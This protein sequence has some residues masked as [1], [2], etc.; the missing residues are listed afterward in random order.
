MLL[1][2]KNHELCLWVGCGEKNSIQ[3]SDGG[4]RLKDNIKMDRR[5]VDCED[6]TSGRGGEERNSRPLP[7]LEPPTI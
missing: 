3:N 4:R 7:G 2:Y 5:E 6:M 1:W